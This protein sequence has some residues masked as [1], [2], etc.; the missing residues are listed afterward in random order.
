MKKTL[1][2]FLVVVGNLLLVGCGHQ[3]QPT[4]APSAILTPTENFAPVAAT[5]PTA[6]FLPTFTPSFATLLPVYTAT[7]TPLPTDI[8][9]N[10]Q[11]L[12]GNCRVKLE[13]GIDPNESLVD[14]Y[15]T[16]VTIS[17]DREEYF[18][19]DPI[20]ISASMSDNGEFPQLLRG[21]VTKVVVEEPALERYSFNLVDDGAGADEKADDGVYTSVF[22]N[23]LNTGIYKFYFQLATHNKNT[24][25]TFTRECYL[26]KTI[27]NVT[28]IA[29]EEKS[30]R[31]IEASVPE[32]VRAEGVGE[33]GS[34]DL[35]GYAFHPRA[36]S[37]GT[38]VL[39]TWYMG[40]DGQSA[41]PNAYMRI[42]NTNANPI[43]EV[44]LLFERNWIGPSY[45]LVKNDDYA[46]LTYC[47][48][49]KP[50][51]YFEDRV[52]SA[53]FDS[54]GQLV[55]EQVRS[56]SNG[57]CSYASGG[58]VWT[59]SRM[60]FVWTDG[61]SSS[62]NPDLFL[63]VA[64]TNGNSLAWKSIRSGA[65]G[66]PHLAIGHGRV[67]MVGITG[68]GNLL[69]VHRFDLEGNETGEPLMLSPLIYE[70]YGKVVM[71]KFK[72]PYVIPTANGWMILASSQPYGIYVAHLTPDGLLSSEPFVS[73]TTL[74]FT[75]G[76]ND[77]LS[78]KGGAVILDENKV[79]FLS[80]NGIV[81]QQWYPEQNEP[82]N[83]GSLFEHRGRLY[84]IYTGRAPS[85]NPNANQ[86]LVRE[87][88]C[89]P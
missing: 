22:S 32:V 11:G 89:F 41:K 35:G 45:S 73:H 77:V 65:G 54:Q 87:L 28:V 62:A 57:P 48:R 81:H 60:M 86:V 79:L 12:S 67:F 7:L 42:L 68:T 85:G 44:K 74:D 49:Y 14:L 51:D 16:G 10:F 55:S 46:I 13:G 6:T 15:F 4:I 37:M 36:V 69:A 75:N 71:G 78:Y 5:N 72:T 52:T 47:G 88:Q 82:P 1:L 20:K 56:P 63:D 25:E 58:S 23:T 21:I 39:A 80:D 50:G 30:C 18:P 26:A 61:S 53:F 9:D 29:E 8:F 34:S 43:G 40:F 70:S 59:G 66:Y 27:R 33:S 24:G 17:F 2:M 31:R 38:T 19:G 64:D 83:F 3:T 84:L 76:F